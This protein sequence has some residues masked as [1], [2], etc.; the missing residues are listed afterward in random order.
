MDVKNYHRHEFIM[1]WI[2]Q[3][4]S[5][6]FIPF[7]FCIWKIAKTKSLNHVAKQWYHDCE[8]AFL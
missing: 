4:L 5:L 3:Y 8:S 6:K 1:I 7:K 2:I